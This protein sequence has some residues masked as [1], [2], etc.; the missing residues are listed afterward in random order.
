VKVFNVQEAKTH[1]SRLL[2]RVA[3]GEVI[4]LGKHGKPMAKLI[5]FNPAREKRPLG[6]FEGRIHIAPDFDDEDPRLSAL[7]PER[8]RELS[9]RHACLS[10]DA[11]RAEAAWQRGGVR[12][13]KPGPSR[14]RERCHER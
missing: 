4:L 6:G 12:H 10:L 14:F 3:A 5:A 8:T 2:G 7:S 13:P 11:F 9:A 1:L